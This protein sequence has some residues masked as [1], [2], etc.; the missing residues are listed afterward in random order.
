MSG[1]MGRIGTATGCCN[2]TLTASGPSARRIAE[3][4]GGLARPDR[5]VPWL[6]PPTDLE[7][8]D[9]S[10]ALTSWRRMIDA[11]AHGP[12][13]TP[14]A[15][16]C[17]HT[18]PPP[19]GP[20]R[21]P[22]PAPARCRPLCLERRAC[23][24]SGRARASPA[25]GRPRSQRRPGAHRAVGRGRAGRRSRGPRR[26]MAAVRPPPRACWTVDG[27]GERAAEAPGVGADDLGA[28]RQAAGAP[29][30]QALR[31]QGPV[32]ARARGRAPDGHRAG[33]EAGGRARAPVGRPR[34]DRGG[35]DRRAGQRRAARVAAA[36]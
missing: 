13:C 33:R 15:R 11:R 14:A 7:P 24:C 23:G 30:E 6:G 17:W 3:S 18:R 20:A 22:P 34:P 26:G 31:Q 21:V 36:P 29:P 35:A 9:L 12:A 27:P 16:G 25:A 1:S 8:S 32:A 4:P 28:G 19:M 5:S 2:P 10:S